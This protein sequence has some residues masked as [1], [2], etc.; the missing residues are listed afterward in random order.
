[1]IKKFKFLVKR[2]E[3]DYRYVIVDYTIG[4]NT[5][6]STSL[7]LSTTCELFTNIPNLQIFEGTFIEFREMVI[8]HPRMC[9][10]ASYIKPLI[11]VMHFYSKGWRHWQ[12]RADYDYFRN[13]TRRIKK[14][15]KLRIYYEIV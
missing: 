6:T 12:K 14:D 2:Q 13:S 10:Y 3:S 4:H 15:Q 1:M 8:N 5:K 9:W 11:H 7:K